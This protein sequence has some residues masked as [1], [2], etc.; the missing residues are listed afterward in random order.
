MNFL[1]RSASSK[2][3]AATAL[4][5]LLV[6]GVFLVEGVLKFIYPGELAAGRFAKIGIPAPEIMGPFVA[7]VEIVCGALVLIGFLTRLAA[8]PLLVNI[9]VAIISTKIPVL[10][11]H[12]FWIFA[13]T[14]APHYGFLGMIHEGRADF[15]MLLGLLFL[16]CV[17]AG[18]WSA[19]AMFAEGGSSAPKI[20]T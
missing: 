6:G 14:K 9:L 10:L 2:A 16:I 3:P 15:S 19:D 18:S 4:I 5:R 20:G 1:V 8:I 11:G 12:G 7:V 13:A 17:G